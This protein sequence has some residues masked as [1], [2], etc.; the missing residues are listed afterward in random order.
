MVTQAAL[1]YLNK[2]FFLNLCEERNLEGF[3]RIMREFLPSTKADTTATT[4]KPSELVSVEF[5]GS[6]HEKAMDLALADPH[7]SPDVL[8]VAARRAVAAWARPSTATT[9]R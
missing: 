2:V 5:D 6:A 7:W 9:P 4:A 1:N 8:E 3:Y